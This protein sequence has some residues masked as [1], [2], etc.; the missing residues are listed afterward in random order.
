MEV[1][2]EDENIFYDLKC[3]LEKHH[4]V[5][6]D[7]LEGLPPSRDQEHQIELIHRITPKQGPYKYLL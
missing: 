1:K 2:H 3:T 7:I 4:R 6:Q 5:F